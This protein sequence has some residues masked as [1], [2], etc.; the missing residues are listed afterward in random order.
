MTSSSTIP[1]VKEITELRDRI[2]QRAE[3]IFK[4][5]WARKITELDKF[6]NQGPEKQPLIEVDEVA[7]SVRNSVP[8]SIQIYADAGTKRRRTDADSHEEVSSEQSRPVIPA[9]QAVLDLADKVKRELHVMCESVAIVKMYVQLNVPPASTGDN[10]GVSV[11]EDI[12]GELSRAEES[13]LGVFDH[14]S[15]Y[16][17]SRGKVLSKIIKYPGIQDYVKAVMEMDEKEI[18]NLKN[19]CLEIRNNY[20]ILRD[21]IIKNLDKIKMPRKKFQASAMY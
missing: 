9:N 14:I 3:Q 13:G 18:I 7:S 17:I 1:E 11:Q 16:H 4:D 10:F 6:L 15:R 2:T 20:F 19:T 8:T 12:I 21:L 5:E